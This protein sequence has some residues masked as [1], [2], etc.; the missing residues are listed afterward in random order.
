MGYFSLCRLIPDFTL[1]RVENTLTIE[2]ANGLPMTFPL[3]VLIP[4]N[5]LASCYAVQ[6]HPLWEERLCFFS[7]P[8]WLAILF[9]VTMVALVQ[10]NCGIISPGNDGGLPTVQPTGGTYFDFGDIT[11]VLHNTLL[12][13]LES[14]K[15]G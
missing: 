8:V 1:S 4:H 5:M 11:K 13:K 2:T 10:T 7:T 15:K 6:P 9:C 12:E 14:L 3:A